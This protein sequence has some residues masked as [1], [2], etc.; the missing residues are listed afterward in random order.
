LFECAGIVIADVVGD[1]L[2]DEERPVGAHASSSRARAFLTQA[3][4]AMRMRCRR[5]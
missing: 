5:L 1:E 2:L 3:R 4:R